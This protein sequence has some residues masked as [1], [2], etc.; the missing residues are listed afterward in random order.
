[1]L[2]EKCELQ[3]LFHEMYGE[4][5]STAF[6]TFHR[7]KLSDRS[8][9]MITHIF[10]ETRKITSDTAGLIDFE[11]SGN[12]LSRAHADGTWHVEVSGSKETAVYIGIQGSF[13]LHE[14][15]GMVNSDVMKGLSFF[16]K[17]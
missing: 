9:W 5:N 10:F 16:E 15:I 6:Y 8:I 17:R 4:E 11:L 1:M 13:R 3:L 12:I 14:F 7:I 2:P